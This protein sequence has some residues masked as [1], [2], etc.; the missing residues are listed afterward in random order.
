MRADRAASLYLFHP[1]TRFLRRK[2]QAIPIL[3]YHQVPQVDRCTTH[4][5]YCTSTV[6]NVFEQQIRF[7]HENQYRAVNLA[8]AYRC[9]QTGDP[10]EKLVAIT[11]DDGYRDF[12]TNAFPILDR[13]GYSATVYLP[14]AYI[15]DVSR[16]F[17]GLDCLTWSEVRELRQAGVE[18]GSHTVTHPQLRDVSAEQLRSEL[19]RSKDDI[20]QKLGERVETF[21]Y[22]YAFPQTDRGFVERLRGTLEESGYRSGVTTV[23]GRLERSDNP[24]FM[25]RLPVNAHDDLEFFRGKLDGAYDWLRRMQYVAK[26]RMVGRE[27][28]VTVVP[29]L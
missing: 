7:L 10:D 13:Y 22:P 1:L 14:T 16:Q 24:L 2:R 8:E 29:Q 21:G 5:Y 11:F 18:F 17:Q 15:G 9:V 6:V 28:R 12:Y 3:M 19:S 26:L 4:P 20:Q 23:I 27:T 25:S